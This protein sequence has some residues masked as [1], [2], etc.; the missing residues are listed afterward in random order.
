MLTIVLGYL[1]I[2]LGLFLVL[3]L[4]CLVF[5]PIE[6]NLQ[7]KSFISSLIITVLSWPGALFALT[8]KLLK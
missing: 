8:S 1:A 7:A 2:G 4:Y 6:L 5:G 3:T